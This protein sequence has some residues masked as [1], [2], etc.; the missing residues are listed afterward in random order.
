MNG[1]VRINMETAKI[2]RRVGY[3]QV[4]QMSLLTNSCAAKIGRCK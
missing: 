2:N 4:M 3:I 1:R